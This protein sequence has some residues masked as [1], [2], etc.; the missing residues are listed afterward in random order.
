MTVLIIII[1]IIIIIK[2]L[3]GTRGL[4]RTH[5]HKMSGGKT[6]QSVAQQGIVV[7]E[8]KDMVVEIRIRKLLLR[9]VANILHYVKCRR[10]D[11][12]Y[13]IQP[14]PLQRQPTLA[15]LAVTELSPRLYI[16]ILITRASLCRKLILLSTD[17]CWAFAAF[18]SL[19][20][21]NSR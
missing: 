21:I 13:L 1:I 9:I 16:K 7:G 18:Q 8:L 4:Q 12:D 10:Y 15:L 2:K 5:S 6:K 19:D 20:P 3:W 11:M 17:H 14:N